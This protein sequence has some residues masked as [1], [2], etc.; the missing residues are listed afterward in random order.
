[1]HES[2]S[3][4]TAARARAGGSDFDARHS[5]WHGLMRAAEA[6]PILASLFGPEPRGVMARRTFHVLRVCAYL[7][8][9]DA[10]EARTSREMM[11]VNK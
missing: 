10:L 6:E 1:M 8:D 3:D 11:R 2:P 5:L 9:R 7:R 4:V